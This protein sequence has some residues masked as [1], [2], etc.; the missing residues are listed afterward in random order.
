MNKKQSIIFIPC[1][2]LFTFTTV[3]G[4]ES[5]NDGISCR[6]VHQGNTIEFSV[7]TEDI[8]TQLAFLMQGLTIRVNLDDTLT[9]RF[10]SAQMVR[11]KIHRHPNEV[12]AQFS[13]TDS[14]GKIIRPDVMPLVSAIN[15]TLATVILN[16]TLFHTSDYK[17]DLERESHTMTFYLRIDES[18]I[19]L[20]DSV[21][22]D[23]SSIPHWHG[24][25]PE[26]QGKRL[27]HENRLGPDGMGEGLTEK[28]RNKRSIHKQMT[29]LLKR[30]EFTNY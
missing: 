12:K 11:R 26:F 24:E 27:S 6:A 15:D 30:E 2:L 1:F 18:L 5:Y 14:I 9:M 10:P 28:N 25:K 13:S 19:S 22:L 29:I 23:I 8:E 17:V 3:M 20:P 21:A 16:D 4:Q 7:R